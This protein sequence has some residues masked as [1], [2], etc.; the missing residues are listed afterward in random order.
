M[1]A[2]KEVECLSDDDDPPEGA[3]ELLLL[4]RAPGM[5]VIQFHI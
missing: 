4:T 1:F 2:V 5:F 3:I